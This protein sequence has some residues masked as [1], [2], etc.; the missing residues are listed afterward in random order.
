M[1]ISQEM[2]GSFF[3]PP[4]LLLDLAL[5]EGRVGAGAERM[6]MSLPSI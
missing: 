3:D 4:L 5:R 2:S 6:E 1:Q